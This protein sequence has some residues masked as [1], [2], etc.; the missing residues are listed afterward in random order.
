MIAEDEEPPAEETDTEEIGRGGLCPFT[1]IRDH[2][3]QEHL[4][5]ICSTK[6]YEKGMSEGS[7]GK[8]VG[9][10][11]ADCGLPELDCD[12]IAGREDF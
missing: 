10:F 6:V 4:L 2:D 1:V 7:V 12:G 5:D 9:I 11:I 3:F 8:E